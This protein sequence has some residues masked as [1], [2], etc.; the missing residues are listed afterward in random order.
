MKTIK[1]LRLSLAM[2]LLSSLA[3]ACS[4]NNGNNAGAETTSKP[5]STNSANAGTEEVKKDKVTYTIF[6]GVAG[7]KDGNTNETTIG[8]MLEDQTGTNFKL[9]FL[10]G[11]LNTKIGTM[12]AAN[13]YPDV[14]I[15][16]AAIEEVL[17]AG[18]FIPLDDLIEKYGPNIKRVYGDDLDQMRSADGKLY[19]LPMSAQV[20]EFVPDPEPTAAFW[21][22]RRVLEEAGYPKIKTLD[23]YMELIENY[24]AK[25]KDEGLTGMV[26]LTH[27][28]R[29]LP[30][31]IRRCIC[32]DIRMTAT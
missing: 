17:N 32:W 11:D 6:N 12:I 19:F 9:E 13:E 23:Q 20:G 4:G 30:P 8:K 15:P 3:T 24:A 14:L 29:F 1:M 25:H 5:D 27:D 31:P 18:A 2:L 16:D 26:S 22:Q 28:W 7:S 21:V 10:V